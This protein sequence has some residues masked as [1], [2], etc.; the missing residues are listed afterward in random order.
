MRGPE[1]NP[2]VPLEQHPHSW[3][4]IVLQSCLP[5]W[6]ASSAGKVGRGVGEEHNAGLLWPS[7][8]LS[9]GVR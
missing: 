2:S 7:H 1:C 9:P 4:S 8:P 6:V 5:S 3:V